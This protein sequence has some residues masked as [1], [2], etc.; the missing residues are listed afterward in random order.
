MVAESII[1]K[2]EKDNFDLGNTKPKTTI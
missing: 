1:Q 2:L